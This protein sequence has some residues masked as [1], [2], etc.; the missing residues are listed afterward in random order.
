[1]DAGNAP[2][3]NGGSSCGGGSGTIVSV[4]FEVFGQVQGKG[5][6]CFRTMYNGYFKSLYLEP[7]PVK[8]ID[9]TNYLT[10]F[11]VYFYIYSCSFKNETKY[12]SY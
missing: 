6:L 10:T 2:V 9:F 1:M 4:E 8:Q 3:P 11:D 12:R 7:C 5:S